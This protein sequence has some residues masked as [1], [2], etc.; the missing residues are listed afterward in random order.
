MALQHLLNISIADEAKTDEIDGRRQ[1][2]RPLENVTEAFTPEPGFVV[3]TASA[4]KTTAFPQGLK[5]FLN[6]CHS[7]RLPEPETVD[8]RSRIVT[9]QDWDISVAVSEARDDMDKAGKRS[10]TVDCC[11]HTK[12]MRAGMSDET[13]RLY[14]IEVC[15][16]MAEDKLKI[17]LSREFAFPKLR[18]KGDIKAIS[19]RERD[20]RRKEVAGV[21]NG[22]HAV[23]KDAPIKSSEAKQ[24][25]A[26]LLTE[27]S[28]RRLK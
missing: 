27:V 20:G 22:E 15:V 28:T 10:A 21:T 23:P 7:S 13:I 18:A 4:T 17:A 16:E 1:I 6:I 11:I 8:M 19:M 3:K 5:F 14:I 24:Q 25:G 9:G 26:P 2:G 12:A